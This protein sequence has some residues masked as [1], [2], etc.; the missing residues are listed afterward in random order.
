MAEA[1]LLAC[2]DEYNRTET[3]AHELK[4][5]IFSALAGRKG[6]RMLR[7]GQGDSFNGTEAA[8]AAAQNDQPKLI[9]VES[10]GGE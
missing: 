5:I 9:T 4:R 8:F 7:I 6:Y 2:I 1:D 3:A 10:I